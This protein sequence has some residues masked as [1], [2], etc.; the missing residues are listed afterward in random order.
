MPIDDGSV[1]AT[2]QQQRDDLR[3]QLTEFGANP[4]DGELE[5]SEFDA[6]FADSAHS[7]AERGNVLALVDRLREQL[8]EIEKALGKLDAGTYGICE[9]CGN[10]ISPERLEAL[11]HSTLCVTCKQ[12]SA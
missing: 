9:S 7:T 10:E 8:Q 11:P 1:R 3:H 5:S 4:D 12:K 6:G 2:L